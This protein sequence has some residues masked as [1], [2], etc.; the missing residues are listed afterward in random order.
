MR[1]SRR[2]SSVKTILCYGDSN[3]WG[4]DPTGVGARFPRDVRWPNRLAAALGTGFEVIAE[5]LNGR[6]ATLD[7][8]VVDGRN[9][10]TYLLP[11]LHSHMPIDLVVIYLGTNDLGDR[12]SLPA[13]D[14]AGAVGRLVRVVR[15]SESGPDGGAPQVLVICPPPF[16]RL[17]PEG[18]FANSSEK[19]RKVG[20]HFAEMTA[21]MGC[22]LLD[23]DGVA[24]YSD[25]DGI[26]LEADGHAAVAEAVEPIV[27]RLLA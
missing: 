2:V 10:L 13:P 8:P 22:E 24:S 7:S 11:C 1:S 19:S 27:R 12:Y 20:R 21:L 5:G 26:H 16:A 6:T 14:V 25:L 17:D 23:L 3:T 4:F 15:T 18:S 9:G